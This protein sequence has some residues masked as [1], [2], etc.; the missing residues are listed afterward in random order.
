MRKQLNKELEGVC[1]SCDYVKIAALIRAG[2]D[3]NHITGWQG[4]APLYHAARAYQLDLA[5]LL[6][7]QGAD[8]NHESIFGC[9]AIVWAIHMSDNEMVELLFTNGA[10]I[11]CEKGIS[12]VRKLIPN[13]KLLELI[14]KYGDK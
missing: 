14:N 11:S 7:K 12:L 13:V 5:K 2:A 10:N 3:V 9:T 6:I 4:F 1:A 8:V